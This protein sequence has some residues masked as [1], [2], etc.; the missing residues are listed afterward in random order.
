MKNTLLNKNLKTELTSTAHTWECD[1][2]FPIISILFYAVKFNY[3]EK[4]E[5]QNNLMSGLL[6]WDFLVILEMK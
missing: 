1:T 6:N 2:Q 5:R 3:F 4:N